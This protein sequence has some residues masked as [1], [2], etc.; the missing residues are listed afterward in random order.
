MTIQFDGALLQ[1]QGVNFAVVV[2][3]NSVIDSPNQ[4]ADIQVG[5]EWLFGGAPVVLAAQDVRG[6]F[7]FRGRTDLAKFLSALDPAQIPWKR[8]TYN[9]PDG[10]S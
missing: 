1:E 8:Y 5:Y 6:N 10:R 9:I 7:R 4:S 3:A 2:V